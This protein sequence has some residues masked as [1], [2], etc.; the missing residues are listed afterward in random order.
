MRDRKN[1][2]NTAMASSM[3]ICCSPIA[4]PANA[5]T[6]RRPR[7]SQQARTQKF[8]DAFDAHQLFYDVFWHAD[9]K[10][11][12][13]IGPA[14][15]NLKPSIRDARWTA[16]PL[17][18]E[19]HAKT[20]ISLSTMTVELT[21]VP[22]ETHAVQFEMGALR[23]TVPV[24]PNLGHQ[25]ND[26]RV[27]FTMSKNNDLN[28]IRYWADWHV[29]L[30]GTDTVYLF[31]N[32]SDAYGVND[33]ERTLAGVEGLK[34]FSVISFPHKFGGTDPGVKINP[35]WAHFAQISSMGIVLR[36]LAPMAR[37][38]LN[39]DIDELA[40]AP[41]GQSLYDVVE[42]TREGLLIL[43]GRW[44]ETNKPA[45]DPAQAHG[46]FQYIHRDPKTS[47]S[48]PVKWII[49]PRRKWVSNLGVH[50]YW[51]WIHGRPL[52]GKSFIKDAFFWHFRGINT[53]WKLKDRSSE[54]YDLD[55]LESDPALDS[56]RQRIDQ[57]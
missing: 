54:R 7:R 1:T 20:R 42:T 50:P 53:G 28:W 8:S 34:S 21:N 32:G 18:T 55:D 49:D 40:H 52:F 29:R 10:R 12:L 43:P 44:V 57:L 9:G 33:V 5:E 30:H 19:L 3:K 22:P 23:W 41:S 27:L 11:I 14:P 51:H 39:C 26:A 56:A 45:P 13:A 38:I 25:A 31:D 2:A 4:L 6:T 47:D 46:G 48:S 15:Y 35:Y 24:Q 17:G 36:R 16:L 37:G